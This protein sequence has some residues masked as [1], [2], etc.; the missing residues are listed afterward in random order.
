ME[1]LQAPLWN[2]R[3]A[4]VAAPFAV[5]QIVHRTNTRLMR[6]IEIGERWK[7]PVRK[8]LARGADGLIA[9]MARRLAADGPS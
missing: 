6:D 8:A 5:N 7:G 3:I 2:L 1:G 4:A 9:V